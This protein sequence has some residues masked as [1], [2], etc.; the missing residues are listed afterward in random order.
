MGKYTEEIQ[1]TLYSLLKQVIDIHPSMI[2][3]RDREGFF[4]YANQG[5]A[6]VVGVA[7]ENIIGKHLTDIPTF[8]EYAQQYSQEDLTVLDTLQELCIPEEKVI[9]PSG[10]ERWFFTIKRPIIEKDG[11]ANKILGV[12]LDITERKHAEIE[13]M[14]Y[15]S[16]L[17][18]LVV[19]RTTEISR[20][21]ELL[22]QEINDRKLTEEQLIAS[23][24]EKDVLLK[25]IH[26]RV[27]NNLQIISSLLDLQAQYIQDQQVLQAFQDSQIRIKA[28]ARVHEQLYQSDDLVRVDFTRYIQNSASSLFSAYGGRS[29]G[30]S[31]R[32]QVEDVSVPIDTAIP[33]ALIASELI[34]NGLKHGFPHPQ[35]DGEILVKLWPGENN[36]YNLLVSDNGVGLPLE[37]DW[38]N[39]S[40]LGLKLVNLLT[41]QLGGQ[42]E[43]D[44]SK[45]TT[46]HITFPLRS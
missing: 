28:M 5:L 20:A 9:Y 36:S 42:V 31:F 33:L 35:K 6:D 1:E 11:K 15:R 38:Q 43:L 44:R 34:A 16:H 18:K 40:T 29:K 32:S 8:T 3:V 27:K 7:V 10:E 21:N 12:S 46:F 45:G 23:L 2:F 22:Q 4:I 17:E 39:P 37:C 13:I 24:A 25:E 26:H 30:I 19:E 14:K 41:R